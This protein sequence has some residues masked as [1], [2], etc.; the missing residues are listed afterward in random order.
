MQVHIER[1]DGLE[2]LTAKLAEVA[3]A[4]LRG[5]L[6][7]SITRTAGEV[8]KGLQGE[9]RSGFDRPTPWTVNSLWVQPA[10]QADL[11]AEVRFKDRSFKG[12]DPETVVAPH[13]FGGGRK[14]KRSEQLLASAFAPGEGAPLDAYG[15]IRGGFLTKVLSGVGRSRDAYQN[16]TRRSARRHSDAFFIAKNTVFRRIGGDIKPVLHLISPPSYAARLAWF[17]T[18]EQIINERL[19]KEVEQAILDVLGLS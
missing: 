7:R 18:A 8:K 10:T 4:R 16:R 1:I 11:V 13:I 3:G 9:M 17:E 6:A 19:P 15:N 14:M 12:G 2:E 5:Y